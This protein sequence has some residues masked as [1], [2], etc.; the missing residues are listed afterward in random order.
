MHPIQALTSLSLESYRSLMPQEIFCRKEA[1]KA[2]KEFLL[3]FVF[4]FVLFVA[5]LA[6]DQA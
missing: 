6:V 4:F 2:Q 5:K 1:P 3:I